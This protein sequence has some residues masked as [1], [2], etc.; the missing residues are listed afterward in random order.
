MASSHPKLQEV[1]ASKLEF[2]RAFQASM[3]PKMRPNSD[4]AQMRPN[5]I[6]LIIS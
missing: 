5:P 3:R 1:E 2:L 6:E 4:A